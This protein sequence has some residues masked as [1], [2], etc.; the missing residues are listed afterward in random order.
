METNNT[1]WSMSAR[2]WKKTNFIRTSRIYEYIYIYFIIWECAGSSRVCGDSGIRYGFVYIEPSDAHGLMGHQTKFDRLHPSVPSPPGDT[3]SLLP[4]Y[5]YIIIRIRTRSL[6]LPDRED[7]STYTTACSFFFAYR[8][9]PTILNVLKY[10]YSFFI[11]IN[12]RS[13][14]SAYYQDEYLYSN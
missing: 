1:V 14:T 8:F 12:N 5:Y 3:P 7:I 9:L 13:V 10:F 6:C 2:C 4:I 11:I